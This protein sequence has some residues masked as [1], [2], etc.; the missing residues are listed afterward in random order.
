MLDAAARV[1]SKLNQRMGQQDWVQGR[2]NE[3]MGKLG[4]DKLESGEVK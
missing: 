3:L 2:L 1:Y 4:W